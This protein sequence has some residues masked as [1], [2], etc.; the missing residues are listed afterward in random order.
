M[1][2]FHPG[3]HGS[4]FGGNPLAA[5]VAMAALDVLHDENLC[6]R[7]AT[8]GAWLLAEL[9]SLRGPIVTD[10]RGRGLFIG[11][12][13]DTR[14]VTARAVVDQLLARGILSKD[15]HGTVVRIAP[16]LNIAREDLAWAVGEIRTVIRKIER[17]TERAA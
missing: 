8:E 17:D 7:S 3:D 11:I 12:E 1:Q 5:A 10:V 4:T 13:V 6:E 14:R 16:P 9:Q 15:T 2:V